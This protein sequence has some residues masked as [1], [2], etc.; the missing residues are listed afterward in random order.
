M[1][2]QAE[3]GKA[4]HAPHQRHQVCKSILLKFAAAS[5]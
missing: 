3:K 5:R 2:R 4:F 1:A